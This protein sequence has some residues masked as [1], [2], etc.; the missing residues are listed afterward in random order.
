M[1]QEAVFFDAF[2]EQIVLSLNTCFPAK[3]LSFDGREAKIQP[4]FMVKPYN[5]PAEPLAV[6]E[7]VP[8]LKHVI[9]DIT[10]NAVVLCVVAQRSLDDALSGKPYYAGKA[11]ILSVQD[12]VIVGVMI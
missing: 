1:T 10:T 7:G 9:P 3:I 5:E 6:I 11:R 4:L 8:A 12:A 2:R